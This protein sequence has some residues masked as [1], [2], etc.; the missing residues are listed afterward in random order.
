MFYVLNGQFY[1]KGYG[2]S[3]PLSNLN[4]M[5]AAFET[6]V[7][8]E[9]QRFYSELQKIRSRGLSPVVAMQECISATANERAEA[10][11]KARGLW[12]NAC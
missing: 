8:S 11:L 9:R 5:H 12:K 3:D 10:F 1:W 6:L 2:A 7:F 4:T